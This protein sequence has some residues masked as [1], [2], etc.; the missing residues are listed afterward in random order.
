[1]SITG[2]TDVTEIVST[3]EPEAKQ[4]R[5]ERRMEMLHSYFCFAGYLHVSCNTLG[6]ALAN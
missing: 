5:F 6:S 3:G 1:M 2:L 4:K